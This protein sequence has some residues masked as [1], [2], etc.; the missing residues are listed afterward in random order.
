LN[1]LAQGAKVT[2]RTPI[3]CVVL[4]DGGNWQVEAEWPDGTIE[5]VEKF[6]ADFEA[7]VARRTLGCQM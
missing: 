4:K 5:R 7:E 2:L 3:F 6:K 1:H